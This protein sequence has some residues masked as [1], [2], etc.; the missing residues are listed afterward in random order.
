MNIQQES[1]HV[2]T[3]VVSVSSHTVSH[4][5]KYVFYYYYFQIKKKFKK[6][7]PKSKIQNQNQNQNLKNESKFKYS[8]FKILNLKTLI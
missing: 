4:V 7:N 8:I 1:V 2:L 3:T 6:S 5:T